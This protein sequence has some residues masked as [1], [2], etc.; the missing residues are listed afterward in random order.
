VYGEREITVWESY[1]FD[2]PDQWKEDMKIRNSIINECLGFSG[3]FAYRHLDGSEFEAGATLPHRSR[4]LIVPTPD[5]EPVQPDCLAP[6]RLDQPDATAQVCDGKD[7]HQE[8]DSEDTRGKPVSCTAV[9]SLRS[10]LDTLKLSVPDT[11]H[12]IITYE[13]QSVQMFFSPKN[14]ITDIQRKVKEPWNIPR[15]LFYLMINGVQDSVTIRSK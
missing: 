3:K 14:A 9:E 12:A 13:K 11:F 15:K 1:E 5:P 10:E 7:A 2:F 8:E 6:A 4:V